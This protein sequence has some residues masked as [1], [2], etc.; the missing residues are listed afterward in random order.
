MTEYFGMREDGVLT[1]LGVYDCW[2]DLEYDVDIDTYVYVW[3]KTT[4]TQMLSYGIMLLGTAND[5]S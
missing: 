1:P 4:F 3:T 5:E 2:D